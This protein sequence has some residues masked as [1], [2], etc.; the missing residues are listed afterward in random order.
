MDFLSL[1]PLELGSENQ[2]L[3]DNNQQIGNPSE[4]SAEIFYVRN[5][6]DKRLLLVLSLGLKDN[7][8]DP[9]IKPDNEA[10]NAQPASVRKPLR[11]HYI[12]KVKRQSELLAEK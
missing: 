5:N 1:S 6:Q 10:W 2:V 7:K 9:L 8:G 3:S 11:E 4:S 12:L